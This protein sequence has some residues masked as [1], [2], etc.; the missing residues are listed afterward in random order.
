MRLLVRVVIVMFIGQRMK[1]LLGSILGLAPKV[2]PPI[3]EEAVELVDLGIL[4][5]DRPLAYRRFTPRRKLD[6]ML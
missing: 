6:D 1:R 5:D 2:E 3:D 4:D